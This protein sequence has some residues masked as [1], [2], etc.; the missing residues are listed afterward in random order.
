M[1]LRARL[2]SSVFWPSLM[3]TPMSPTS[4]QASSTQIATSETVGR[5][6]PPDWAMAKKTA[7]TAETAH[8]QAP[9]RNPY[10]C[11]KPIQVKNAYQGL[12]RVSSAMNT[13]STTR[14]D[15][16]SRWL[17]I[18]PG[19]RMIDQVYQAPAATAMPAVMPN[20]PAV[21]CCEST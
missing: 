6:N 8:R 2:C 16:I 12:R 4:T 20:A 21:G 15:R 18:Q 14:K 10:A 13:T 11:R 17:S 1:P 9:F 19:C 5:W 3:N 7:T